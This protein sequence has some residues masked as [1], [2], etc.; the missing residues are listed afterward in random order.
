MFAATSGRVMRGP[1][2]KTLFLVLA[3][4]SQ[5]GVSAQE[6]P[7]LER[8]VGLDPFGKTIV[9][10]ALTG[11]ALGGLANASRMPIG[12]EGIP[13]VNV[14]RWRVQASG[15][16]LRA[17]L[18]DLV[19]ADPRYEWRDDNGVVVF[20][21]LAAW[22][23]L[24]D[25]LMRSVPPMRADNIDADDA[26]R[27]VAGLFGSTASEKKLPT[28]G[29]RFTLDVPPGTRMEALNAIV[30]AH[31]A[32]AWSFEPNRPTPL[33]PGS[34]WSPFMIWLVS[35][36]DQVATGTGVSA[37]SAGQDS[38][39][40]DADRSGW[41]WPNGPILNRTVGALEN[42]ETLMVNHAADAMRLADLTFVPM[43]V[44]LPRPTRKA[45]RAQ[46]VSHMSL[47]DALSA[48]TI[49]D[50]RYEW[51]EMDG[52]V[53]LRPTVSWGDRGHPLA[54]AIDEIRLNDVTLAEA[55]NTAL[56]LFEPGLPH[57]WFVDTK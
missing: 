42:G 44:E 23:D 43:G 10:T 46:P 6:P 14:S 1:F 27:I 9:I 55:V 12:L 15:R 48:I 52:V 40:A 20:R 17:V 54:R 51:R 25:P 30:R 2:W 56:S 37:Y 22:A 3:L 4:A 21:P 49:S 39:D 19:Q 28:S 32:M 45:G 11:V 34:V 36:R 33:A 7:P 26:L 8:V 13:P 16:P 53:V 5:P 41:K 50:P 31:G 35:V 38:L 18:D 57:R 24:N 47:R 29:K